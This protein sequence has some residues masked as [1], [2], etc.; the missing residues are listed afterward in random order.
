VS[1]SGSSATTIVTDRGRA[2][3]LKVRHVSFRVHAGPDTG[4][5]ATMTAPS[6]SI[7]SH[8]SNDLPL[9]DPAVSRFHARVHAGAD[10]YRLLDPASTN[11]TWL[12]DVRVREAFLADGS[13][14][15]VGESVI[16][17]RFELEESE[18]ELS[19]SDRFGDVLG[20]SVAM[21]AIFAAARKV[22]GTGAT[23]LVSGETGT[24]KEAMARAIHQ[25]SDRARGPFVVLDCASVPAQLI[26]TTLL[27]HAAGAY[28]GAGEAR[29]GVFARA[30]G[31]T[32]FIDEIGELPPEL[33]PKL[34]RVLE[35][36]TIRPVGSQVAIPIDARVIAASNRDLRDLVERSLFRA[37]LYYRIAVFPIELPP[38]R[39]RPED[40]PLLA[41]HLLA[42]IL[43]RDPSAPG[44]MQAHLDEAFERLQHLPWPGNV[45]ELRNVLERA[46][47]MAPK[48]PTPLERLVALRAHLGRAMSSPLPLA[49]ARQ[50][51]DRDYLRTLL[52]RTGGD[53]ARAA[54][55]AEIHP[56]SLE[57][58]LRRYRID[59]AESL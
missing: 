21:R 53:I 51:A 50:Q 31:G 52:A 49:E 19:E 24:G 9:T 43:E 30:S 4:S 48:A 11:G 6:F 35:A 12:D 41:G 10:G 46:V 39:E 3:A 14:L 32:L 17:V 29:P 36:R 18:I 40:I 23:V 37:D 44:W 7:G 20:R 58:L 1:D 54:E 33:Q 45:R 42:D 13:N 8:P 47:A 59:R 28:T 27:G 2:L 5:A 22:A 56:K 38:L 16:G 55:I 26:E 15:R 34:L 57:R 25:H